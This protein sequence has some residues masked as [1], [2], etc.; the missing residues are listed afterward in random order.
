[1]TVRY[2]PVAEF[3]DLLTG[4]TLIGFAAPA[5]GI[6]P[7]RVD[8]FA[9][10]LMVGSARATRFS[11]DAEQAGIRHGWCGFELAGCS[12][13]FAL[14]DEVVLRCAISGR[15]LHHLQVGEIDARSGG[16]VARSIS[17]QNLL[18]HVRKTDTAT[19]VRQ[20]LPFAEA[21]RSRTS[22]REF[23]EASFLTVFQKH[24]TDEDIEAYA[25]SADRPVDDI[26]MEMTGSDAFTENARSHIPGPFHPDFRY[27]LQLFG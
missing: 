21:F 19:D 2:S 15:T 11:M 22:L 14:S 24:L 26:L 5:A 16:G 9:D 23:A 12:S 27:G 1:M 3:Q 20:I 13:A 25:L 7:C 17:V 18:A 4:D 6:L 8:L 10:D